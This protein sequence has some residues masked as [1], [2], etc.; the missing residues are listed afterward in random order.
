MDNVGELSWIAI[1]AGTIISFLVGWV[2]YL[3]Q[4]FGTIWAAGSRVELGSASEMPVF[5]MV[6]QLVGLFFLAMVIGLTASMNMLG[7]AIFSI[8]ATATFV[9]SQGGFVQKTTAAIAIDF[10]YIV[11]SGVIMIGLQGIF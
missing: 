2:W 1:A 7:T 3:P 11:I 5:A 10:G 6:T 8:L 9:A 4:V